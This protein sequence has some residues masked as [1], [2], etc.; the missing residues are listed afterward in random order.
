MADRDK[1]RSTSMVL[2]KIGDCEQCTRKRMTPIFSREDRTSRR[3]IKYLL[4]GQ[5]ENLIL[6]NN[7]GISRGEDR[8]RTIRDNTN[9]LFNA[10]LFILVPR[11]TRLN[12]LKTTRP[13][14]YG[15]WGREWE[16]SC[17]AT[18]LS[19][20]LPSEANSSEFNYIAR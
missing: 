14:N 19:Q 11:T 20:A 15:L 17:Q 3:E 10:K 1:K 9:T 8:S 18:L 6:R 16:L 12:L 2:L 4:C 5:K 13:E 7:T